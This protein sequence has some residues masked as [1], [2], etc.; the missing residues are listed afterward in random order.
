MVALVNRAYVSTSTTGTGTIVL[1]TP[2]T[3]YQSFA[4]AGVTNG[5]TV[6]YT[7]LDGDAWEIGS[8]VYTASGTT[9]SR[10]L[11]DSSTGSLL[12]LSGNAEVF[13]TAAAEDILQPANNLSD[14]A[15]AS[16]SRTNL[17]VAIGSDVQAYDADLT[18]LGGLAK[19]DGNIIVG[20]G[21]TW[22]AESGATARTSL[23]LT[24]GTNVQAYSSVLQN[25]TASFTTADET[26]LD[27]ITVTQAVSLD[28]MEIDIAALENGMVYKGDWNAGSGSFPGGGSAQTGWFYYVSGAGTVNGITF[29]IGDNIVATTDNASTSTYSGNWSKHDQTDAVQAVVGLTG[30]IAKG[31]LLA[32]LNVEDGADV[33]DAGNVNPLVDAH[34]NVS[35]ASSG[36][37]LNWNGSDYAWGS[38]D[39]ST[40]MPKS[41]GTFTGDVTFDGATAGRDI[42][43]ARSNNSLEFADNARAVFGNQAGGDL[44][45]Y[46]NGSNSYIDEAGTGVLN[47]RSSQ[48]NLAKYTG[49]NMIRAVA[50]GAVTLLY[51]N[52]DKFA[53]TSAGINVT[54]IIAVTGTVDGRDVAADGTKL[55]GIA[56][57]ATNYTDANV[58]THL[59]TSTA[60]NGE[61]LSWTG[62]DYDWASVA[63]GLT[64][65]TDSAS[66]FNTGLGQLAFN[67]SSPTGD[68]NVAIGYRSGQAL[69]SGVNNIAIGED[70]LF[71]VTTTTGNIGIGK[72]AIRQAT[73]NYNI[74]IG[75]ESVRHGTSITN[76][77]GIGYRAARGATSSD[78]SGDYNIALGAN[79]LFGYTSAASNV[80]IGQSAGNAIT[81]G[82][83]NILIGSYAGRLITTGGKNIVLVNDGSNM[84]ITT[85]SQ[86]IILGTTGPFY[87][88]GG[89]N[90][91]FIGDEAGKNAAPAVSNNIAIGKWALLGSNSSTAN[92][93]GNNTAIGIFAGYGVTTGAGNTILGTSAANNLTTGGNNVVLGYGAATSSA[94]ISNEITLGGSS[95]NRFRIPGLQSGASNG[96]VMTYNSSSGII[97]LADAAGGASSNFGTGNFIGG[98]GAGAALDSSGAFYNTLLGSNAGNDIT[99]GDKNTVVG[100]DA[101]TKITT[102]S[103]NT[104]FGYRAGENAT[105]A[106]NTIVGQAAGYALT[107]GTKNTIVGHQVGTSTITGTSNTMVGAWQTGDS[108]TSGTY[109]VLLGGGDVT[110][111]SYN[112]LIARGGLSLTTG[113]YNFLVGETAGGSITTGDHNILL[114]AYAGFKRASGSASNIA[115]GWNAF[116]GGNTT[117]SNTGTYN[118]ALGNTAGY[119]I[120]SGSSNVLLGKSAGETLTSGSNNIVIGVGAGVSSATVS[121][122]I[123]IGDA[124]ATRFRLP[125]LQAGASD[126][127]VMTYNSSTGLI[128]L[129]DAAAGGAT[130]ING[131]SDAFTD[132]N[133]NLGLGSGALTNITAGSGIMNTAVGYNAG[134]NVTTGD[135]SVYLGKN[136]GSSIT[137]GYSN[138]SVGYGALGGSS[139]HTT[140]AI[141]H[142]AVSGGSYTGSH[143]VGIGYGILS[144]A[145]SA[146]NNVAIG[147]DALDDVT[148]GARNTAV[149]YNSGT[150]ITTGTQNVML[151]AQ[152]ME[153]STGSAGNNTAVGTNT[154]RNLSTGTYNIGI[155]SS[156]AAGGAI[157]GNNNV[158]LGYQAAHNL[159]SGSHN[160]MLGNQA[161]FDTSSG[162]Y[163]VLL[164]YNAGGDITSGS[165]NVAIGR[166]ALDAVT[167]GGSMVAIGYNAGGSYTGSNGFV[168][169]GS[170]CFSGSGG[171]VESVGVGQSV[172]AQM[173]S[174]QWNVF[175]GSAVASA[176]TGGSSN[177][178]IGQRVS[179]GPN[180]VGTGSNNVGIGD[181]ALYNS[182]SATQNTAVGKQAGNSLT[183]GAN[184]TIIGY[185]ADASSATISNE[186]TIGNTSATRF[187]LPGLQ[188]GATN[189]QVMTYDSSTGLIDLANS[190]VVPVGTK[191]SS[192]TLATGDV[193]KYVQV[194]SGGSI[195]IPNSTFSEGD[196]VSIFNNT[197][198][199]VTITCSITTAYIGGTDTDEA[200]V[201]LATRGIATILFISGTV[202]VITGN[203][204]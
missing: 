88:A 182:T 69:T 28:Q 63:P 99:T 1:G 136:A 124:N 44:Q 129:A 132:S 180:A 138:V 177:V 40:L 80:A 197:S 12:N 189:G 32:A 137:T 171:M 76:T 118:L 133:D 58:D 105:G 107:T 50:D 79:S 122:E 179:G 161:G 153:Y 158:L 87:L 184:N 95:I 25:T 167:T 201:T 2:E 91:I 203:V 19:S 77:I 143:N 3:G 202:C 81:T 166:S 163:N 34:I 150:R 68:N 55:D 112:T 116:R 199:D 13:V 85:G 8:G 168:A 70:A 152:A 172:G 127:Q 36:Q 100:A 149:G 187:R 92:T 15:N 117:S 196:I 64:G 186:I 101:G 126:G 83:T 38:I 27:Y 164:G 10:T 119:A 98:T 141:G 52:S 113:S 111:G 194:G 73:G 54:G 90:N 93:G 43:F 106:E 22:V 200:S 188:A 7:I 33:T 45:I 66:P 178:Y 139:G 102:A 147:T 154:M 75:D 94:T 144:A 4:D 62:T 156:T 35:G 89:T 110:T 46:H 65:I 123:T 157:S 169:V 103:S 193:G 20:N 115:M 195:T 30:S 170:S 82:P 165:N 67:G 17:G 148:T 51:N 174:G 140:I 155:G 59:N 6:R 162:T 84:G 11:D 185:D 86:N 173:T 31:S 146:I 191:T 114:G 42:V 183:T 108:L 14:L 109:N 190:S 176:N 97:E 145:T 48:I 26:K 74:G 198:G 135:Q 23:G 60:S 78:P 56:T 41:G 142:S 151:G 131:L 53:T 24:I 192:Y 57:G 128:D 134:L 204:S 9:L 18:A 160:I 120:T 61:F 159:N 130:S 16:T 72:T 181:N 21:S 47:I 39:T 37:Y 5:Q 175:V 29:A 121:N 125:G 96:Q 49:E 104:F 71:Y